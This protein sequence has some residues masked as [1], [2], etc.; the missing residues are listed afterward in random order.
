VLRLPAC[1]AVVP[2]RPSDASLRMHPGAHILALSPLALHFPRRGCVTT[3]VARILRCAHLVAPPG[4]MLICINDIGCR[5]GA[6]CADP[7]PPV[8]KVS[9]SPTVG[10]NPSGAG[11][12][13]PNLNRVFPQPRSIPAEEFKPNERLVPAP[14]APKLTFSFRPKPAVSLRARQRTTHQTLTVELCACHSTGNGSS[15]RARPAS[16]LPLRTASMTVRRQRL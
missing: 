11:Q 4:A 12:P 3:T 7:M 13:I 15:S 6:F 14:P 10:P 8:F 9:G 5:Q 2:R 16:L 1:N